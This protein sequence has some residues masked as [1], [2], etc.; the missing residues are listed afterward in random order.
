[1]KRIVLLIVFSV[2][3]LISWGQVA[4]PVSGGYSSGNDGSVS[5]TLGQVFSMSDFEPAV[6]VNIVTASV[7]E[8]VQ[9][10]YIVDRLALDGVNPLNEKI[11]V[12]P[13]PAMNDLSI[14]FD[15]QNVEFHYVLYGIDGRHL[16]RGSGVES[17]QLD[18]SGYSSGTYML[19]VEDGRGNKNVYKI[20]KVN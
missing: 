3:T 9:Q 19:S 17:V 6:T 10:P 18:I 13:N 4:V 1:M 2:F 14:S 5:F 7:N 15:N 12:Y 20:V 16:Q 8:G 11:V